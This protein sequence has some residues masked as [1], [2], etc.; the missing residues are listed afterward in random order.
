MDR[1]ARLLKK[2]DPAE[3]RQHGLAVDAE[4]RLV[5]V[6]E[7]RA[8]VGRRLE[9]GWQWPFRARAEQHLR[10]LEAPRRLARGTQIPSPKD[11]SDYE[12]LVISSDD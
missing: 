8:K 7:L 12:E 5:S 10:D 11:S 4:G 3:L 6:H 1:L 9:A 2:Q